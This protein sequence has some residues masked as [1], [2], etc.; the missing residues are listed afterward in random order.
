MPPSRAV[1]LLDVLGNAGEET[2]AT[3]HKLV[4]EVEDAGV[5]APEDILV[6]ERQMPDDSRSHL[7]QVG[8]GRGLE[9]RKQGR[10]VCPPPND[11]GI[12]RQYPAAGGTRDGR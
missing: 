4:G 3:P 6:G 5:L 8:A 9:W 2:D 11:A 7:I 12:P 1:K 10:S